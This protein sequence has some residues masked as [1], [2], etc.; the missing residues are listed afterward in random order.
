[1]ALLRAVQVEGLAFGGGAS[2]LLGDALDLLGVT[3]SLA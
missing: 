2:D 1:V 3:S